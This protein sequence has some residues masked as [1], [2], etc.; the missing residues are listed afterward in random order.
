[1]LGESGFAKWEREDA[2]ALLPLMR[3]VVRAEIEDQ[4]RKV[5]ASSA[6]APTPPQPR[7]KRSAAARKPLSAHEDPFLDWKGDIIGDSARTSYR[8][9]FRRF[10][11]VAGDRAFGDYTKDDAV[12][13]LDNLMEIGRAHV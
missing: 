10:R 11:E 12:A 2:T 3:E 7:A 9:A 4:F 1:M 5:F 8:M 13:F 6:A